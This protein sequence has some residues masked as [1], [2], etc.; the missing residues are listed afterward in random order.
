MTSF[1]AVDVA[2][3]L[4]FAYFL[5]SVLS[6]GITETISRVTKM[7]ARTL[8][9]W[10]QAVLRDP[11][12]SVDKYEA[13]LK[14]PIITALM[15]SVGRPVGDPTKKA[16]PPGYI[17]S[18]HFVAA[19][20]SAGRTATTTATGAASL[21]TAIGD[22]IKRL[23]GTS[24]GDSLQE[25]Y[26]RAG[27]DVARFRQDAEAWFDDHMERVSGLYRRWSQRIVW[28]AAAVLVVVLNA[29]SFRIAQTLWNDPSKRA[30]I[31]AK[32]G[33]AESA[34]NP[35]EAIND[36]PLPI[37]WSNGYH[38]WGWVWMV[39]GMLITLGAIS[40]GAPF[41]FDVLSRFS[42]IRQTGTPPPA[43]NATRGGEGDQSRMLPSLSDWKP[44][45]EGGDGSS[46][47]GSAQGQ[48]PSPEA[49]SAG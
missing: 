45:P 17:P 38:S 35:N 12:K 28:I 29:N 16:H 44:A 22:D 6:T 31:V 21:W 41:W 8:E 33:T 25:F 24:V 7:R 32:A 18:P 23:H 47:S 42:R 2:I 3:G 27:G 26:D 48:A 36:L 20:L 19:A 46:G 5:L 39:V 40:L 15:K 34:Q 9:N 4:S 14:T 30:A 1:P 49:A 37:G 10:L 11:E 13:F 43:S